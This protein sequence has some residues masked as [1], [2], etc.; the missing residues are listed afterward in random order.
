MAN[1]ISNNYFLK[2]YI[3]ILFVIFIILLFLRCENNNKEPSYC[4]I[5]G[6]IVWTLEEGEEDYAI[7]WTDDDDEADYRMKW[8]QDEEDLK[9]P[10]YWHNATLD[11]PPE[12]TI[13]RNVTLSPDEADFFVINTTLNDLPAGCK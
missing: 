11:N 7:A 13:L 2:V 6:D 5:H 1:I 3:L 4:S 8:S 9:S 10:G 12:A